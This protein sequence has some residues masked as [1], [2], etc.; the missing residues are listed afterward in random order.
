MVVD[1]NTERW[2]LD[3]IQEQFNLM[4]RN[5]NKSKKPW[6]AVM[7]H[8]TWRSIAGHGNA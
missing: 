6:K 2:F 1:L 7:G 5:I 8:H 4:K 3:D